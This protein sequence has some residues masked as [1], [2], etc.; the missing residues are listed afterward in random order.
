MTITLYLV[1]RDDIREKLVD[2]I[3]TYSDLNGHFAVKDV[4]K[5]SL[6]TIYTDLDVSHLA[7]E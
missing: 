3:E 7:L 2:F 1:S 6:L 5:G 4:A